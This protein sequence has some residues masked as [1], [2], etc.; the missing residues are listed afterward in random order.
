ME[1]FINIVIY[2]NNVGLHVNFSR[3]KYVYL[4]YIDTITA[5]VC[6]CTL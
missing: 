1:A 4:S 6:P 2:K 5:Q 3:E